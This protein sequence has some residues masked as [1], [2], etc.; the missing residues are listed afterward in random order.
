MSRDQSVF[1]G[2]YPRDGVTFHLILD[3][4]N[5]FKFQPAVACVVYRI[6]LVHPH[7]SPLLTSP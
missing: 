6:V 2:T 5:S 3:L 1:Q 7:Y 4:S